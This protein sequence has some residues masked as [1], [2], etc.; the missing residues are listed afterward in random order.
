VLGVL[1]HQ[2]KVSLRSQYLLPKIALIDPELTITMP[3]SVTTS[4]GLDAL[5]QLIE[6]FTSLN[7]N[8][9]TDALCIEGIKR[10]GRS[11]YRAF[12]QGTDLDAREDMSLAALFGGVS[13][14]NAK[15][16]AV[17]GFAGPIGGISG[18]HHGT[19]CASL[20]AN[21]M[22]ANVTALSSQ[23]TGRPILDRYAQIGKLL[24]DNPDASAMDGIHWIRSFCSYT[25]VLTLSAL[26][27][28]QN[29]FPNIIRMAQKASSMQ[30]NPIVLTETELFNILQASL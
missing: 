23:S 8:P 20:L 1:E 14:A 2:V 16:G 7:A 12:D 21:V 5:T 19:V 9:I 22:E 27:I 4:T 25:G 15:L 10:V 17:H 24:C 30:G 28:T 26:G 29:Q 11:F 13:L 6:P 3:P 18:A